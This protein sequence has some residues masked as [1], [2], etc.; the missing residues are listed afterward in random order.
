M[1]DMSLHI[2]DLIENSLCAKATIVA[3]CVHIDETA[4]LLQVCVEDNGEG[5]CVPPE[6]ALSPFY[7]T[8]KAKRVGF[9]LSF[10]KDAAETAGGAL[11]LSR[12]EGLRGIS[13]MARMQLSHINRPP[14]GDLAA[15]ISAMILMHPDVDF[16]LNIRAGRQGRAFQLTEYAKSRGLDRNANVE[17]ASSAF[18]ALRSELE[19]WQKCERISWM[20]KRRTEPMTWPGNR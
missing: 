10:L 12:S 1:H 7:T 13:V 20:G 16:R 4:D 8:R 3:I 9:G 14:L 5:I 17:L 2:M 6:Q 19:P 18:A 15:T 11:S